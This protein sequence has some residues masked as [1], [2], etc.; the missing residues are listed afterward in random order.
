MTDLDAILS[1][2][3]CAD[4]LGITR[5]ELRKKSRGTRPRIP[6][7]RLGRKTVRYSPRVILAKLAADSGVEKQIIAA[8]LERIKS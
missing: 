4:W 2:E 8:A 1:A 3:Q 6:C 5:A 7:F